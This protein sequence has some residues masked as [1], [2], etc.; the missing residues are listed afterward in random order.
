[1]RD[2]DRGDRIF[3]FLILAMLGFA[4]AAIYI[5]VQNARVAGEIER[6]S[7][8]ELAFVAEETKLNL[9]AFNQDVARYIREPGAARAAAVRNDL[10]ILIGRAKD[11]RHGDFG[12]FVAGAAKPR[13]EAADFEEKLNLLKP[14]IAGLDQG[15]NAVKAADLGE[16]LERPVWLLASHALLAN[17]E[18]AA[19]RQ[20]QLRDQQLETLALTLG[21]LATSC[22][23][24]AMLRTQNRFVRITHMK[25]IEATKKYAFLANHDV[26]TGLPN[27]GHF[28]QKLAQALANLG[29]PGRE[30]ALLTI[31]LD[32]FKTIND[33]LGHG[34]GD[35]LLV[36][37][38]RRLADL[39]EAQSGSFVARI[40]GDEFLVLVEGEDIERR[41]A[42]ISDAIVGA[43][44]QPY[45]LG[46]RPTI[47]NASIGIAI[48]PRHGV[49]PSEIIYK[50][51]TALQCAKN[52][53]RGVARVFDEEMSRER[54]ERLMLESALAQS[55]ENDALE[56]LYQPIVDLSSGAVVAVEAIA[57]W[58]HPTHGVAP[59]GAL[60]STVEQTGLG[61]TLERK[62][63]E[64]ICRD[65]VA[66]PAH[67]R[68]A[69]NLSP[70]QFLRGNVVDVLREA[71]S[72]S[73]LAA[74][75]LELEIAE[76][77]MLADENRMSEVLNAL[78]DLGL[79][80]TL[81]NFGAVCAGLAHLQHCRFDKLKIDRSLIAEGDY[82]Q[83]RFEMVQTIAKCGRALGVKVA[84]EGI[85]TSEQARFAQLAGC[86]RAQ[87][88]YF[89]DPMPLSDIMHY[90]PGESCDSLRK[91]A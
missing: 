30:A 88:R 80:L 11:F 75:R 55:V 39:A 89:A 24:I 7:R 32:R 15:D 83:Q 60:L 70:A 41:A 68:V 37:V 14:L 10:A 64:R 84:A 6:A 3:Q 23:L 27:R 63:L 46:G 44:G 73:G 54:R 56:P 87:G 72:Q 49:E 58:R 26:L 48:A 38:A 52:A 90:Q 91:I 5:P 36:A 77:V 1:M 2:P 67:I 31:D 8:F 19:D 17:S 82:N 9:A 28:A 53:G 4:A 13:M 59:L 86:G 16:A 12:A 81:D 43:L 79:T 29:A 33:T 22:G 57:H 65:A 47:V 20:K 76:G 21:L 42:S 74:S 78:Q 34:A 85:D 18:S 61:A 50:S 51:D 66:I 40:G 45:M 25:Q 35:A 62:M 71:L 69:V